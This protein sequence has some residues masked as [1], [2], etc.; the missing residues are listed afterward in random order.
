M[1]WGQERPK[2]CTFEIEVKVKNCTPLDL[3]NIMFLKYEE[4]KNPWLI[5]VDVIDK[6]GSI[7]SF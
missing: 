1:K 6:D 2:P 7:E 3:E 4:F 5:S